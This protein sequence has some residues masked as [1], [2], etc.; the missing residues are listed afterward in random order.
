VL[1]LSTV[2]MKFLVDMVLFSTR[3]MQFSFLSVS[4]GKY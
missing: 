2:I 3:E 4:C 1:V